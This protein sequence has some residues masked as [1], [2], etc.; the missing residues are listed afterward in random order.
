MQQ[1][2][3]KM[4]EDHSPVLIEAQDCGHVVL[5]SGEKAHRSIFRFRGQEIVSEFSDSEC[6]RIKHRFG[7]SEGR[8][9]ADMEKLERAGIDTSSIDWD[10]YQDDE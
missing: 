10:D 5:S 7:C 3:A 1:F 9:R 6:R 8:M 4:T 2:R